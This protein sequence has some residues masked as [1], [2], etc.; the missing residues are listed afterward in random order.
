MMESKS[1]DEILSPASGVTEDVAM[2]IV[3][4]LM[5]YR[6]FF[7][8][9]KSNSANYAVQI[10]RLK[11]LYSTMENQ[12][13]FERLGLKETSSDQDIKRAYTEMSQSLHPDK[14]KDVPPELVTI[15]TKVY[16]KVQDA[17]N[18]I[19]TPDKRT[20]YLS[21][22]EGAKMERASRANRLLDEATNHLMRGD[23]SAAD[24]QIQSAAELAPFLPRVKLIVTWHQ[25]K[26][27]KIIPSEAM[28]NIMSVS[29]EEKE[30]ALYLHVRG[31][32]HMALNEFEKATTSFKNAIGKDP[33]FVASRREL[34]LVSQDGK[35]QNISILNA[36]LRDVV[37]LFFNKKKK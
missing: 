23:L 7:I 17:Y 32:C 29:N 19:K 12:T 3:H 34:S 6:E 1:L 22:M 9:Q 26:T 37:G 16:D 24:A 21:K 8:G 4:L 36:D 33:N 27:K 20:E 30:G 11:K 5:V 28:R 25:L 14:L 35:K 13:S 15:A 18:N 31:L 10:D 2:R